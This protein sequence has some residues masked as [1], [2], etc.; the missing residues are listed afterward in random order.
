MVAFFRRHDFVVTDV[1]FSRHVPVYH[2]RVEDENFTSKCIVNPHT[3]KSIPVSVAFEKVILKV[4]KSTLLEDINK[5][6]VLDALK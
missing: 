5:L 6:T 1:T 2:N 4:A 3:Q